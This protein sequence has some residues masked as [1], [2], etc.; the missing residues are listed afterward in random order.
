MLVCPNAPQSSGGLPEPGGGSGSLRLMTSPH[1]LCATPLKDIKRFTPAAA[2]T[3]WPPAP[4]E[5]PAQLPP[6]TPHPTP[7]KR[8]SQY[9]PLRY[10]KVA[11]ARFPE[12]LGNSLVVPK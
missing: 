4:E 10:Q 1:L 2:G 7:P 3:W 9:L 12:V 8:L 6:R 11:A 5:H